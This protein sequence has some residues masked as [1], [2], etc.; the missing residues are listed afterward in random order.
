MGEMASRLASLTACLFFDLWGPRTNEMRPENSTVNV[1]EP[2]TIFQSSACA[3]NVL[4]QR[5]ADLSLDRTATSLRQ[6]PHR[7]GQR[8]RNASRENGGRLDHHATS[9][10]AASVTAFHSAARSTVHGARQ[11]P[12]V[13]R[14]GQPILTHS[15]LGV[16][17]NQDPDR[18]AEL[19]G[20][21]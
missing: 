3:A 8:H 20:Q 21:V 13:R 9:L 11:S 12:P 4:A 5:L 18:I 17:W 16:T 10:I 2:R 1:R 19:E 7:L 14:A 6:I 15:P